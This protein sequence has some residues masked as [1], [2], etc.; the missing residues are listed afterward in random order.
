MFP[1]TIQN[2]SH[3]QDIH[4]NLYQLQHQDIT[5]NHQIQHLVNLLDQNCL[6][7]YTIEPNLHLHLLNFQQVHSLIL[8][9]SLH[10]SNQVVLQWIESLYKHLLHHIQIQKLHIQIQQAKKIVLPSLSNY[11]LLKLL[12]PYFLLS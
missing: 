2:Q 6:I 7:Q 8:K 10:N 11:P 4:L 12:I 3:L 1:L 5:S 9:L